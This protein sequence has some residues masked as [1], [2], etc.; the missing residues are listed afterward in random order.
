[1]T[2]QRLSSIDIS[3]RVAP[4]GM[5]VKSPPGPVLQ[6]RA[7]TG[8]L[9]HMT[10]L[11]DVTAKSIDG[12]ARALRDYAGKVVLVVN[13]AS[14][15]G[16]TPHYAGLEALHRKYGA[17]GLV[18]LGFP[19]NQFGAQEP[20]T[21]QEIQTFCQSKYDVTFPLFAKVDVNGDRRAPVFEYLATQAS[22]PDGA[23]DV[24][25]NFAKFVVDRNGKLVARFSPVTKPDAPELV[26]AIEKALG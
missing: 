16:L 6:P 4:G 3:L 12:Q 13:V 1:M 2:S 26:A 25:W 5:Q 11:H 9:A 7:S 19:C 21:E 23:G 10:T 24:T 22:A 20:G 14:A 8:T 17:R 15:C 18:V